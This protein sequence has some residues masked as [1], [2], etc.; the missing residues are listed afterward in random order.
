MHTLA[1]PPMHG[2]VSLDLSHKTYYSSLVTLDLKLWLFTLH[3]SLLTFHAWPVVWPL[4][5]HYKKNRRKLG[6]VGGIKNKRRESPNFNLRI[7]NIHWGSQFFKHVWI[8]N[9]SPILKKNKTEVESVQLGKLRY[10]WYGQMS[11]GKMLHGQMS[12]WQL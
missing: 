7:L 9:Y 5:N 3:L 4:G 10:C 2:Q 8:S 11:P 1:D 6:K 12:W